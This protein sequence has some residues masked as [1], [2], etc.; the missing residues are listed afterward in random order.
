MLPPTERDPV[1]EQ[2]IGKLSGAIGARALFVVSHNDE[3]AARR[4][5]E[6]FAHDLQGAGGWRMVVA[7]LPAFDRSAPAKLYASRRFGLLS[8]A[9]REQLSSGDFGLRETALRQLVVPLPQARALPHVPRQRAIPS[10]LRSARSR[11]SRFSC[12][13]PSARCVR[14]CLDSCP[15]ASASCSAS[16]RSSP[17]TPSCTSSRSCSARA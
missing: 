4:A 10:A 17:G 16:S 13:S 7:R 1:A 11:A 3:A 2:V 15:P 9:D 5:A 6:R 14:S 12:C 8:D